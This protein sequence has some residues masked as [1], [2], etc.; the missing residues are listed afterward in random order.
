MVRMKA[1]TLGWAISL[2][3]LPLGS[4]GCGDD[5]GPPSGVDA[6][7]D[8]GVVPRDAGAG[9]VDGAT[10]AGGPGIDAGGGML[11]AGPPRDAGVVMRDDGSI[12]PSYD[13]GDPFGD[14]GAL[15]PPAWV[16]LDVHADGTMCTALVACG[17]DEVGTW[18]VS[19]GCIEIP[20][21]MEIMMCPGAMVTSATGRARGRVTFPGSGM[22]ATRTAQAEVQ[23]TIFVPSFCAGLIGGCPALE[24]LIQ[25][26]VPDSA[27]VTTAAGD[28]NCAARQTT[29]ID[30][31]DAYTTTATQIVG[32]TSGKHWDYC[33]AGTTL[34]YHDVSTSGMVEPGIIELTR[35]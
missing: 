15:G 22:L 2:L 10:D 5:D 28:C 16:S 18:D 33:V 9:P 35:R 25:M 29:T 34:R 4:A 26:R 13:A 3:L 12:L 20:V 21:P 17:G 19:G 23:A 24:G 7:V 30:D 14:A 31:M 32:T 6:G 27:C 8:A 11:D 1:S